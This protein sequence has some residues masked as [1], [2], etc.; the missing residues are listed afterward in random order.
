MAREKGIKMCGEPNFI[1][2]LKDTEHLRQLSKTSILTWCIPT[3][4]HKITNLWKFGLNWSFKLQENNKE[5]KHNFVWFQMY[6]RRLQAWSPLQFGRENYVTSEGAV[7]HKLFWV[8][9]KV[10]SAF[11]TNLLPAP[12]FNIDVSSLYIGSNHKWNNYTNTVPRSGLSKW[13]N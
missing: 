6:N 10:S 12:N 7:S 11:N 5:K 9:T 8:I 4:M 3:Y 1:E 2:L 13:S